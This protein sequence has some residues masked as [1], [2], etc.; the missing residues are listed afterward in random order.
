MYC[1][2][3]PDFLFNF[4]YDYASPALR[5]ELRKLSREDQSEKKG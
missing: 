4:I 3:C 5:V 2:V 1:L